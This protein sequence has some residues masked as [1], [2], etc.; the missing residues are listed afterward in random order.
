MRVTANQITVAR[1]LGLPFVGYTIYGDVRLRIWGVVIGALIGRTDSLDGYLARRQGVTV[2]GSLLDPVADKVFVVVCYAC[3]VGRG[4]MGWLLPSA[5]LSRELL[6]TVLRSTLEGRGRRLPSTGLA[7]AK[8]WVQ[9]LGFG[10]IVLVPIVGMPARAQAFALAAV[11]AITWLSAVDYLTVGIP[12]LLEPDR[13]RLLHWLRFAGGALLPVVA[14][15]AIASAGVPVVPIIVLICS[16]MGRGALDNYAA[17]R[18]WMQARSDRELAATTLE[19]SV[20]ASI[21]LSVDL[22]WAASLWA[23]VLLLA[24]ALMSSGAAMATAMTLLATGIALGG[25]ARALVKFARARAALP[26]SALRERGAVGPVPPP[27][28][29]SRAPASPPPLA[30]SDR[31]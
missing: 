17:H 15:R 9:M 26:R 1:L 2:L 18:A 7:K 6:V 22:S 12:A 13:H 25:T 20:G 10:F 23:E 27:A 31:P 5:I 11:V 29:L 28:T 8:T 21:N 16:E 24:G 4:G 19:P 30:G 14:L 3:Y